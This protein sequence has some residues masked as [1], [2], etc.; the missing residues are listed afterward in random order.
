MVSL[1]MS[2]SDPLVDEIDDIAGLRAR[3]DSGLARLSPSDRQRLVALANRSVNLYELAC[4]Q[5]QQG[6]LGDDVWE[7]VQASLARQFS[8]PGFA[9]YWATDREVFGPRFA[10]VVDDIQRGANVRSRCCE[11]PT[12]TFRSDRRSLTVGCSGRAALTEVPAQ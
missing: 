6:L 9:E 7:G 10:S 8:R 1:V 5:R 12:A 2:L 3:A 11:L 4:D